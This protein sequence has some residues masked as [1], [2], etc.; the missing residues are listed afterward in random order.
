MSRQCKGEGHLG[1]QNVDA[2][3]RP[4]WGVGGRRGQSHAVLAGVCREVGAASSAAGPSTR[5]C[6]V[7]GYIGLLAGTGVALS[8]LALGKE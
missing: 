8:R 7:P 2:Q 1:A 3:K 5:R 4:T 6:L